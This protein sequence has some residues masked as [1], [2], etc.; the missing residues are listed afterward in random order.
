MFNGLIGYRTY[1]L[2]AGAVIAAVVSFLT[3][4]MTVAEAVQAALIGSGL[5]ALRAGVQNK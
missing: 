3:G 4:E 2:A 1:I 5:A